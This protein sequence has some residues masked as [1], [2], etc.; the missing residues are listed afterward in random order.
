MGDLAPKAKV[1][2]CCHRHARARGVGVSMGVACQW[3]GGGHTRGRVAHHW[4]W[5]VTHQWGGVGMSLGWGGISVGGGMSV[6]GAAY[7]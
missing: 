3:R 6:G 4:G 2:R 1:L 5:C 7:P